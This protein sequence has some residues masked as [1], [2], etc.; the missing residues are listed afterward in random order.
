[1]DNKVFDSLWKEYQAQL[2]DNK[3][4][5]KAA[6]AWYRESVK[7]INKI[8]GNKLMA[9]GKQTHDLTSVNRI[10]GAQIGRMC[11]FFYDP[12]HAATLP[13]FDRF[14]LVI[15]IEIYRDGFLG[16]NL[17]YLPHMLRARLL[18][19][20]YE[21][22]KDRHLSEKKKLNISYQIVKN[23]KR[24]RYYEPCLKR[25][26]NSHVRSRFMMV[27]PEKWNVML[28]LPTE[29]FEKKGKNYVWRQA[30]GY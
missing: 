20:I 4:S 30:T 16:L 21:I 29:R 3:R 23:T 17:H 13:Y 25:Y 7:N 12:K 28:L 2:K 9:E 14:P 18:D 27:N 5:A 1:M 24:I 22:Y 6:L 19:S 26:L 11:L 8:D 15:P 10:T